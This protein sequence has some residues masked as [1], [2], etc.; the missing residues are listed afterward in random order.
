MEMCFERR[1]DDDFV[2]GSRNRT[3]LEY[4]QCVAGECVERVW[5]CVSREDS[6]MILSVLEEPDTS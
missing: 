5:N 1:F 4:L 3:L 6:T 2:C